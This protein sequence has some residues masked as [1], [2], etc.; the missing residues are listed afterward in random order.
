M[1][2]LLM[3]ERELS[4]EEIQQILDENSHLVKVIL[5]CQNEGRM[6]DSML[7]QTRLQLNLTNLAAIA[8]N[9]K[10]PIFGK[11]SISDR[12]I[13]TAKSNYISSFITFIREPGTKSIVSIAK[14]LGISNS[15][16]QN[17]VLSYIS[18]LKQHNRQH[19]ANKLEN[20][21]KLRT[22]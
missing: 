14:K 1:M 4:K 13:E 22:F 9:Y 8:D 18:F 15:E 20:E 3:G 2:S 11:K 17:L 12:S 19:E 5:T 7:Y 21:F 6:M 16:A 10:H